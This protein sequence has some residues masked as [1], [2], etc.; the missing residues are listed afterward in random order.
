VKPRRRWRCRDRFA[1]SAFRERNR[2]SMIV[3]VL[4]GIAQCGDKILSRAERWQA[5][6]SPFHSRREWVLSRKSTAAALCA[7]AAQ[8]SNM[9]MRACTHEAV[10]DA[11]QSIGGEYVKSN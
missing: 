6:T 10:R 3:S 7:V 9:P 4:R 1:L 8:C 11:L 2:R 5:M